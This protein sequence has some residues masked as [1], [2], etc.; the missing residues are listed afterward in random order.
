MEIF[1]YKFS[2]SKLYLLSDKDLQALNRLFDSIP[3]LKKTLMENIN[4]VQSMS[5]SEITNAQALITQ[6]TTMNEVG[7]FL[8][9]AGS[10]LVQISYPSTSTTTLSEGL[11]TITY[12]AT[13][14]V[15]EDAQDS[16][17][18]VDT[19]TDNILS[20]HENAAN[21]E[22]QGKELSNTAS[23]EVTLSSSFIIAPEALQSKSTL[24][25][26]TRQAKAV[27][28]GNYILP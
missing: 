24:K 11:K 19:P 10:G 27:L 17:M 12:Q 7:T 6:P 28:E 8:N 20:C 1:N 5:I 9:V 4:E 13:S 22:A 14:C 21:E 25:Y 26:L 2:V 15:N 23:N 3:T 16:T 18:N